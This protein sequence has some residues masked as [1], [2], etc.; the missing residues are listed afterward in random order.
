MPVV[1]KRAQ[2][3]HSNLYEALGLRAPHDPVLEKPDE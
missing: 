2:I 3:V 1:R